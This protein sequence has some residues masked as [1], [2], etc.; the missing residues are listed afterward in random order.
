MIA[1]SST[2]ISRNTSTPQHIDHEDVSAEPAEMEDALL[3]DDAADQE[4]DQ[5][6]DRHR[7]PSTP[8]PGDAR[9]TSGRK[10]RGVG[11]RTCQPAAKTAPSMSTRLR[12]VSA[13]PGHGA[14]DLIQNARNR[15]GRDFGSGVLP[16][17]GALPRPESNSPP[18]IPQSWPRYRPWVRLRRKPLDQPGAEGVE[19]GDLGDVDEDVRRPFPSAVRQSETIC[20]SSAAKAR[21]PGTC[22]AQRKAAAPSDRL[23]CRVAVHDSNSCALSSLQM[24]VEGKNPYVS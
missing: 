19:F 7:A 9:S 22:R 2:P 21:G 15:H 20:S 4:G 24:S 17:H 1:T 8:A 3:G 23:Q 16:S 12:S 14:T 18:T 11:K 6:N 10:L 13:D 5:D